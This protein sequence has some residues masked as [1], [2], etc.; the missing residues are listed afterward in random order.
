MVGTSLTSC[1][2]CVEG[3]RIDLFDGKQGGLVACLVTLSGD[4]CGTESTHDAGNI[5]TDTFD[6]RNFLKTA[7]YGIVVKRTALYDDIFPE[8]ACI[9]KLD[10]LK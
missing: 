4:Q 2:L 6:T 5:R 3:Q 1:Q 7:Q 9:G 8:L 10:Y